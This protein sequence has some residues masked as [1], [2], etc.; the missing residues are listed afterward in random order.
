MLLQSPS[1]WY[2]Q[3]VLK[4]E[5]LDLLLYYLGTKDGFN[6]PSGVPDVNLS[7]DEILQG[8]IPGKFDGVVAG[9]GSISTASGIKDQSLSSPQ[10]AYL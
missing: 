3:L 4:F 1:I 6:I 9:T 5:Q 10:D 2:T 8:T 7:M